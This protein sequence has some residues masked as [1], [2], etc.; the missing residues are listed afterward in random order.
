MSRKPD[1]NGNHF[2]INIFL[3]SLL[4]KSI[5]LE[6]NKLTKVQTISFYFKK[7]LILWEGTD[8]AEIEA[9]IN[10]ANRWK[11]HLKRLKAKLPHKHLVN[12]R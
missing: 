1:L 8:T 7:I 2:L 5:M 10:A 12:L 3:H 9:N 4:I 11:N 6:K